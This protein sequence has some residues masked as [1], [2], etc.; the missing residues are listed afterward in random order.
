MKKAAER[1][2]VPAAAVALLLLAF[3]ML[4]CGCTTTGTADAV[5]ALDAPTWLP[6]VTDV[7][8]EPLPGSTAA[9][10]DRTLRVAVVAFEAAEGNEFTSCGVTIMPM[11]DSGRVFSEAIA[12]R[13]ALWPDYEVL[14]YDAVQAV[15]T[16]RN[17]AKRGLHQAAML[18]ELAQ[19]TGADAV[20]MGV[21]DGTVWHA[22]GGSSGSSLYASMRMV[23]AA[24]AEVMWTID[25]TVT[26]NAMAA[27]QVCP[28]L[29]QSMLTELH[30]RLER[31]TGE[32]KLLAA[33]TK[34]DLLVP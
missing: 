25:G 11:K 19:L 29:A 8:V 28:Q 5:S 30:A 18:E 2:R 33:A 4:P 26:E 13:L 1:L 21:T 17:L 9:E 3:S 34:L 6:P 14:D 20:L 22:R 27:R 7:T 32:K 23:S 15:V 16:T 31:G 10:A 24:D 12:N